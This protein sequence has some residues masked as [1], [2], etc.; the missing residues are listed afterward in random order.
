[1]KHLIPVPVQNAPWLELPGLRIRIRTDPHY[2][3]ELDPDLQ[4]NEKLN[5]DPNSL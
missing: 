1:V 2:F 5:P 4:L 3:G